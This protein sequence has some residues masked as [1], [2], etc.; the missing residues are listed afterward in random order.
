MS[1]C[2]PREVDHSELAT[3]TSKRPR[4]VSSKYSKSGC[5]TCRYVTICSSQA[6]NH[7]LISNST[8]RIKCDEG[9]DTC[10]NCTS[11]GRICDG[12]KHLSNQANL[13]LRSLLPAPRAL[14]SLK[15]Q[16]NAQDRFEKD[17]TCDSR[18]LISRR[19][20]D[21]CPR[22]PLH[23]VTLNDAERNA[24][25]FFRGL[26]IHQLP[27]AS[28]L[29]TPWEFVTLDLAN[30]QPSV[31][32]AACACAALHRTLTEGSGDDQHQFALQQY[33]KSS[34][35]MRKYIADLGDDITESTV[36][37]V[38]TTCLLFF[39]YETFSGEDIKASIHLN[40][41]LRIIHERLRPRGKTQI[42]DGRHLVVVDRNRKSVFNVLVQT[43]VRL[44][45][46]YM[47]IGHDYPYAKTFL[48]A[49]GQH[50]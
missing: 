10:N 14:T 30:T 2:V 11:T 26:T 33:N 27:C 38:L 22:P 20:R 36:L 1:P 48:N 5:K 39:T 37:V 32:A 35:L 34:A 19:L 40:I 15:P 46:D 24:L 47:L 45:A 13:S 41:G 50:F 28:A 16:T 43:F 8:R 49:Y 25:E 42:Q 29:E 12:Y 31:A 4:K 44:D 6:W 17:Q 23:L 3:T 18:K 7:L 9:K 21:I